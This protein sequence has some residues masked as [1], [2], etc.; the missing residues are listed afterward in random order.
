MHGRKLVASKTGASGLGSLIALIKP[1][2]DSIIFISI[3]Q[4]R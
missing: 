1:F 2:A 4:V 3:A